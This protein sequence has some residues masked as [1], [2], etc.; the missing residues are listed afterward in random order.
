L[1][2]YVFMK[3]LEGRPRSYDRRMD[4]VSKGRVRAIKEQ[5]VAAV[6]P[7]AHVL[8]VGCGTGELASMLVAAGATVDGFDRSPSMVKVARE[9]IEEEGLQD[10]FTVQQIGVEGMDTFEDGAY[11][12]VVATLVFSELSDDERRYALRHAY[13]VLEPGGRLVVADEVF[14]RGTGQRLLHALLR[15][16]ALA[17]VYLA[18]RASPRPLAD[19][20]GDAR[21]AGFQVLSEE[22]SHGDAFALLVAERLPEAA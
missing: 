2:S 7:G 21:A 8:E 3:V 19:L 5:V 22:R 14:P 10:R 4:A 12:A 17:A 15:A 11:G 16:P 6:P 1:F 18:F 13:R 20:A 9:R